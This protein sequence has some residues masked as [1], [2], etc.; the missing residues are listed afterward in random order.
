M[1]PSHYLRDLAIVSAAGPFPSGTRVRSISG[2]QPEARGGLTL[3][4]QNDSPDKELESNWLPWYSPLTRMHELAKLAMAG[5]VTMQQ[6]TVH[7]AKTNLS[8]LIDAAMAG[9][10]IVIAKG[11]KPVVRLVAIP[12]GKFKIGLLKGELTGPTPDFFEPMEEGDLALWE[13]VP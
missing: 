2:Q 8:R 13:G 12:Q 10:D 3:Y 11:N 1:Y 4:V 5:G 6:F 9:E 7:V